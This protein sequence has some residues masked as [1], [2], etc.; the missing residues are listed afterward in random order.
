MSGFTYNGAHLDYFDHP[1]N[2][3]RLNERAVEV[4][5]AVDFLEYVRWDDP[6][7]V[8]LEVGNVLGHYHPH[9]HRVV[10]RYEVAAGVDN[11]DVFDIAGRFDFILAIST[12][13]HVRWDEAPREPDGSARAIRHLAELLNPGGVMLLTVPLGWHPFLDAELLDDGFDFAAACTLV[14]SGD[15]WEQTPE[16]VHKPYAATTRWAE[17]VFVAEL[18]A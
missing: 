1:Y 10:D 16:P 12:L 11:V 13:E 3:T 9:R 4:P 6:G 14:R 5:I 17:S 8:G 7:I 2:D 18:R 15:G